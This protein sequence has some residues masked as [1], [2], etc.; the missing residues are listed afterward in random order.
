MTTPAGNIGPSSVDDPAAAWGDFVD[1]DGEGDIEDAS[2]PPERYEQGLYYPVCIGEVL[3]DRYR[4]EHKLG[5][6]DI[7]LK[8]LVPGDSGERE[9]AMQNE[10]ISTVQDTSR[11]L[12]YR[13]T[14]LLSGAQGSHRVLTFPLLGPNL[15]DHAYQTSV[16]VRRSAARQLLQAL[17]ALHDGGLIHR[18]L[19]SANVMYNLRPLQV[20]GTLAAKYKYLGRPQKMPLPL[21]RP[22]WKEGQLVMPMS[23]HESLIGE[24]IYLGDF[25][26]AAKSG[27]PVQ[28]KAQS[29]VIYCAPERLH[30]MNPSPASDMW[31]YMCIFAELY[32]GFPLFYGTAPSS[33]L[34]FMVKTLGPL[35][36]SWKGSYAG[37]GQCDQSC[38]DQSRKPEPRLALE[39]KVTCT[40]D[41]IGPAEQQLVFSILQRGLSYSPAN[42][43]TAGQ[44]LEDTSFKE[45]MGMYGL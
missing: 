42:R 22:L 14:F 20:G 37:G 7:A 32:L 28:Q 23:P 4:I 5:H 34:D 39:A 9:Y 24:T 29:P 15:R 11:L 31:S 30:G 27:T 36:E 2:E 35:P 38:Y 40:R 8:I 3:A 33:V 43:L 41:D 26:L 18:D 13:E 16:A 45:L 21:D 25:G 1:S 17:K 44:L 6:G 19:N 12:T 10:I